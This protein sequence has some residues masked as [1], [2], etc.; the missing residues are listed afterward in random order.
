M[1][2]TKIVL[3]LQSDL[4]LTSPS[5]TTPLGIVA[6]DIAYGSTNVNAELGTLSSNI[7]QE[8]VDRTNAVTAEASSRLANDASLA[9][10]KIGRAS[11]RE[12]V[13]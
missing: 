8:V 11:C 10:V 12:R 3:D 13:S 6:G 2:T 9:L 7:S 5:I 4:V 1:A